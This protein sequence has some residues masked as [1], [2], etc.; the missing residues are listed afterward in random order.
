MIR[1]T[2]SLT[3]TPTI[4]N[5][6][7]H[8]SARY[9]KSRI[10]RSAGYRVL[11]AATGSEALRVLREERPQ[12]ALI[13]VKLPDI[14]GLQVCRSV[15]DDPAT[16]SIMVL[17]TSAL[18]IRRE[19]KVTG[20][21][22]G[23]DG[24]L[25]EPVESDELLANV[26]ALLR[27][28]QSEQR[29][30]LALKATQDVVYE[31]D[32]E[33]DDW[34][35][36]ESGAKLFGWTEPGSGPVTMAWWLDRVHPDDRRRIANSVRRH[37]ADP[38]TD[39]LSIDYRVRTTDGSYAIV[40]DRGHI[41]RDA[42]GVALRMIGA[43]R[44]MTFRMLQEASLRESE[45]RLQTLASR[46]EHLVEERTHELVQSQARL[47]ALARELNLTEQRERKRLAM[48][49]HDHLAQLLVLARLKL[50][51]AK[52]LAADRCAQFLGQAEEALNDSLT[53]TRTLVADLSPPVLH[54]FGLYAG[55]KWLSQ[56]MQRHDLT[57]NATI[58]ES[59]APLEMPEDHV[60][61]V[62]QSVRELLINASKHAD[63][64]QAF[65]L[66]EQRDDGL[67][68]EVWDGGKGFAEAA[69]SSAAESTVEETNKFGLFSIRERM[70]ALDGSFV[71]ES[72]PGNG[73][74]A[75]LTVPLAVREARDVRDTQNGREPGVAAA[76]PAAR[77]PSGSSGARHI[78]VLLVDD[79]AMVRQGLRSLL[80]S[81][82][83]VSVVG[84]A[85]NGQAAVADMEGLQ[86]SVVVMDVNMPRM[87]GIEATTRIKARYPDTAVIGLSV[88]AGGDTQEAMLRAGAALVLTKEAAVEQL[89][90]AILRVGRKP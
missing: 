39:Y 79:H 61:L 26:K 24:Y 13:D 7:D 25:V 4:L 5:V 84:E 66:V 18:A 45:E 9:A 63:T 68:I 58:P 31:W 57:V 83:D 50:S 36:S 43:I 60:V 85:P 76:A 71:I 22:E 29:L 46:L 14:D 44:D 89:Y 47:R 67:R 15:K 6:D 65:L 2:T 70:H 86:P 59:D 16:A 56:Y 28:Y 54:D 80:E 19:D 78:R 90:E 42:R 37:L 88:N 49:L 30:A 51:Q 10:L 12:L 17:L 38:T 82:P 77:R 8:E 20:L 74:R 55:L 64:R 21:E 72:S 69:V 41:V 32:A 81:S 73:T 27:L 1:A 87:N 53:Y 52:R 40:N 35:C 11:E 3:G 34:R 75:T 62:F 48:E 33:T 23:A